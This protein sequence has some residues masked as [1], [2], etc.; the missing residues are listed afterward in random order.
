MAPG[1]GIF[2]ERGEFDGGMYE[3]EGNIPTFVCAACGAEVAEVK[4]GTATNDV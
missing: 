1:P 4:E 3:E 2:M